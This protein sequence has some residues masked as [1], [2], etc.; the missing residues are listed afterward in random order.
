[1]YIFY[2]GNPE[3][4]LYGISYINIRNHSTGTF[5]TGLYSVFHTYGFEIGAG[6]TSKCRAGRPPSD[7]F[8]SNPYRKLHSDWTRCSMRRARTIVA[9]YMRGSGINSVR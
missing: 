3:K 5:S 1:M 6:I 2:I 9:I 7:Q 4:S 8:V